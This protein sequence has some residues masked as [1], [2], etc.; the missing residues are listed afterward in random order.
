M[1]TNITTVEI[2]KLNTKE[3]KNK[4]TQITGT[5]KNIKIKY[6]LQEKNLGYKL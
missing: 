5:N 4:Q 6:F 1:N 3:I 2:H